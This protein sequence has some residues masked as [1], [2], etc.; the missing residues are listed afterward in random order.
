M[1]V[2]GIE[3]LPLDHACII[4]PNHQSFLDGPLV[5]AAIPTQVL[6]HS[7]FY[8]K[9]DHVKNALSKAYARNTNIILMERS[10]LR[11][12]LLKLAQVLR[13]NKNL[14]IFPEGSR[15]HHGKVGNFK[16]SFA[17]L[18]TELNIPI[19]PVRITGAYEAWSRSSLLVKPHKIILEFLSAIMP[20][21]NNTYE[22]LADR[23]K[24]AIAKG[25]S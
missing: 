15:T 7:Y 2:R 8:A 4:A 6:S 5:A 25:I 11:N 12:S 3:N 23:V 18:S 13:D 22:E 21:A 20:E 19:I 14:I 16:K 17:I 24:E 9:E 1:E 10:N